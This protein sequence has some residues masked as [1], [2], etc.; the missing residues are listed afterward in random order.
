MKFI[1]IYKSPNYDLRK[2]GSLISFAIIHYTAMQTAIGAI[3]H[4]CNKKNQVSSHF[5]IDKKGNIFSLVD[6]KFRAWHAGI[7]KWKNISDINSNSIGIELDNSGHHLRFENYSKKQIESLAKLLEYIKIKY[8]IKSDCILG[9]S[10]VSPYRK[11]DPGE[12]F[13]WKRLYS[14]KILNSPLKISKNDFFKI[15]SKFE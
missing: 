2:K 3:D 12:K 6:E 9:H 1:D 8:D 14:L 4:L 15:E 10:D 5:L 7:S 11:I 13:P